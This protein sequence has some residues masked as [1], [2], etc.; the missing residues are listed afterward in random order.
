LNSLNLPIGWPETCAPIYPESAADPTCVVK[1]SWF[2][3]FIK[4]LIGLGATGFAVSQGAPFWF[5]LLNKITN[6]RA[7]NQPPEEQAKKKAPPKQKDTG[8]TD[9]NKAESSS[10]G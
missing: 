7:A 2:S 8:G 1:E 5:D 6:L 3:W 4:K 10:S 9:S